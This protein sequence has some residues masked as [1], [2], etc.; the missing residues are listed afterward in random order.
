MSN[1]LLI[2][3]G[4]IV[5]I[6]GFVSSSA[7]LYGQSVGLEYGVTRAG[8]ENALEHPRGVG[9]HIDLP[10]GDHVALRVAVRHHTEQLVINRSP[11]VGL[12]PPDANCT[13]DVFDGRS[14]LTTYG[15]GAVFR[16]PLPLP[17]LRSEVYGLG[18]GVDVDAD[19]V[20]RTSDTQIG[21]ITPDGLSPAVA[22]GGQLHYQLTDLVGLSART[23]LVLP[24]FGTCGS[25]AWFAFCDSHALWQIS[26][27]TEF[28]LSALRP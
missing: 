23:G 13:S 1:R 20:G 21:P 25:D 7:P 2:L 19:F 5:L 9:G 22:A 14:H 16:F 24:R 8:Y 27:G 11:C 3:A 12:P 26:L 18:M 15:V 4:M 10:L 28:D 17:R 6:G